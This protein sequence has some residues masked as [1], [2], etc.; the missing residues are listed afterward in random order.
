MTEDIDTLLAIAEIA[1]V[2]VGFAALA[3]V[4]SGRASAESQGDDAF[5]LIG[6]VVIS[7]QVIA[8]ALVPIVLDRFGLSHS[9]TWRVS[10]GLV[11]VANWFVILFMNRVTQG[12]AVTH[13]QMRTLS[14]AGWILEV[15]YQ[16][17]LLLCAVGV[18]PNQAPAF[19]LLALVVGV[20]QATLCMAG[21][22]TSLIA[23]RRA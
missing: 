20:L 10:G 13:R 14:V 19:Y 5:R 2:F 23:A 11:F 16:V 17:P 9:T 4:V 3:T 7:A 8:A 6:A 1:G 21:L 12:F 22:V 15:F 18:W